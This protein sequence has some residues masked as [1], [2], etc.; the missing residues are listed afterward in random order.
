MALNIVE[1]QNKVNNA[2]KINKNL[3]LIVLKL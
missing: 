3:G 1:N 2:Q